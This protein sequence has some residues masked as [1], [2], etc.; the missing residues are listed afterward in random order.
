[1]VFCSG[2]QGLH[3]LA[4]P[5]QWHPVLHLIGCIA[6][7][8]AK[9]YLLRKGRKETH[10]Q[11]TDR[12]TERYP[13]EQRGEERGE[14]EHPNRTDWRL[15]DQQKWTSNSEHGMQD[16]LYPDEVLQFRGFPP[17]EHFTEPRASMWCNES[18]Q[19]DLLRGF[20]S[21]GCRPEKRRCSTRPWT[22]CSQ[23]QQRETRIRSFRQWW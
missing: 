10:K 22:I 21:D 20:A 7:S 13:H 16:S 18:F 3:T 11:A 15:H 2:Y 23:Q 12:F 5:S 4:T 8:A 1:M 19:T 6:S 14:D 17:S 9:L